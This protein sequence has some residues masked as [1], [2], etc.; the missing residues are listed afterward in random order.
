[1]MFRIGIF[2]MWSRG[3]T[4]VK[5]TEC[6]I[7]KEQSEQRLQIGIAKTFNFATKAYKELSKSLQR[8]K[9]SC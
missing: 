2:Q 9:F 4:E 5:K 3:I 6:C 1:M 8:A 7:E